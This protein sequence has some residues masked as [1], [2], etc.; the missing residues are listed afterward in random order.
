MKLKLALLSI[1][2]GTILGGCSS[3][4]DSEPA[5]V[6]NQLKLNLLVENACGAYEPKSGVK[7][8]RHADNPNLNPN[9]SN[10]EIAAS[11]P[12]TFLINDLTETAYFT[13]YFGEN[14]MNRAWSIYGLEAGE[15]NMVVDYLDENESSN[16]SCSDYTVT[17]SLP[18]GYFESDVND[19]QIEWGTGADPR[20][21]VGNLQ[22]ELR[23]CG[24]TNQPISVGFSFYDGTSA[25]GSLTPTSSS[26][27]YTVQTQNN[28][29][30]QQFP[31][32]DQNTGIDIS[33]TYQSRSH[34]GNFYLYPNELSYTQFDQVFN[35]TY[36][37]NVSQWGNGVVDDATFPAN[38]SD[39]YQGRI[40]RIFSSN[41]NSI[42]L[43]YFEGSQEL[44]LTNVGTRQFEMT[45][46]Q[47]DENIDFSASFFRLNGDSLYWYVYSEASDQIQIPQV[48]T[49]L[50]S[51]PDSGELEYR[52]N[53]KIRVIAASTF[54]SAIKDAR[55]ESNNGQQFPANHEDQ[56]EYISVFD[57]SFNKTKLDNRLIEDRR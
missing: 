57:N 14:G 35:G 16:C 21:Y 20:S 49:Y 18:N 50:N 1:I 34:F 8:F 19:A 27:N 31:A 38:T 7:F 52:T 28:L 37:F 33:K 5:P 3:S 45:G 40:N 17:A 26:S 2:T 9:T 46:S 54:T 43:N 6:A 15:Y 42:D 53:R 55:F 41:S 51:F 13:I 4:S 47:L 22:F 12:G 44:Y 29:P 48:D 32:F 10:T 30:E 36:E 25:Y 24:S 11:A 23:K 39:V 56:S